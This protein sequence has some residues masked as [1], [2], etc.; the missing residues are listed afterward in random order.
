MTRSTVLLLVA[1]ICIA[2]ATPYQP[3][4]F[5]GG[6]EDVYLGNDEYMISVEGNGFTGAGTVYSYFHRRAAEIV[7]ENECSRYEVL[8]VGT[9][10]QPFVTQQLATTKPSVSGRIL[11]VRD[12]ASHVATAPKQAKGTCF[13][14]T[15]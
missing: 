7:A 8:E 1:G 4:G 14:G 5:T 9:S 12:G 15:D 3:K 2:C 6:Y 11:C 13:A 10:E